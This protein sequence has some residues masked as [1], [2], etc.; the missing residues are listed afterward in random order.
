MFNWN[1]FEKIIWNIKNFFWKNFDQNPKKMEEDDREE[2]MKGEEEKP[3][4]EEKG[5]APKKKFEV[6]K[7]AATALWAWG[8]K[9]KL[10]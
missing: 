2:Q 1:E 10:N 5:G 9:K 3:E 4:K 8:K 6:K 7:W